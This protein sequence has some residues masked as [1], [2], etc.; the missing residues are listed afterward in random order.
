MNP[1]LTKY[2]ATGLI[3]FTTL[4]VFGYL[5]T[6]A[7]YSEHL[8]YNEQTIQMNN[9]LWQAFSVT[10]STQKAEQAY[11]LAVEHQD[12][13]Q[14]NEA[15]SYLQQSLEFS[16]L[17]AQTSPA[18][19]GNLVGQIADLQESLRRGGLDIEDPA[20]T[21]IAEDFSAAIQAA[22][23]SASLARTSFEESFRLSRTI[24]YQLQSTYELAVAVS[25]LLIVVIGWL[26]WRQRQ[27]NG[28]LSRNQNQLSASEQR[29]SLAMRGA[30]DGLWDWDLTTDNVYYSPRWCEMLGYRQDEL[31]TTLETWGNLV[32]PD[33][34]TR[35]LKMVD[36]YVQGT[37]DSFE[38]E[39]RMR[40]KDGHWVDL[41]SRAFLHRKDDT[42]VRLVG[43]HVDI[44]EHK[45]IQLELE[46]AR[47]KAEAASRSKSDFLATMS[48]EIRTPMNGVTGM[49][50]LLLDTRLNSEQREFAT[51]IQESAQALL[52]IINDVLD[53][54]RL[55]Q[56]HLNIE[57]IPFNLHHT[58]SSVIALLKSQALNKGIA[59]STDLSQLP[60][61]Q[62]TGDP[63]RV[64]Q[65]LMNL[66][67]NAVK[68]TDSGEVSV[69]VS[70]LQRNNQAWLRFEIQDSGIGIPEENIPQLFESFVQADSSITRN[71]GGSGLGLAISKGLVGAMGG[72]IGVQSQLNT[73]SL[74]WF[75][76]PTTFVATAV[77]E[78]AC[79]GNFTVPDFDAEQ[80]G[81]LEILI[82][83][84]NVTNQMV[85]SK[86]VQNLGHR[87]DIVSDGQEAVD[88]V[89]QKRY[90]L[91]Y[92]DVR[93]PRM[94][95]ITA[96]TLIRAHEG[97]HEHTP[98]IALTAN[99]TSD[100]VQACLAAGMDGFLSKPVNKDKVQGSLRHLT[101]SRSN[102]TA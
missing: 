39:F 79:E 3:L 83:E 2:F 11:L 4:L 93:M 26:F 55:E 64:R 15:L 1:S 20:A 62:I 49:I 32:H 54:S 73:G 85:I 57:S 69:T 98:I 82:V 76:V 65:I 10:L 52:L 70:T 28:E 80:P 58:V 51:V 16:D 12:Q 53:F 90:D 89:S 71:Y 21:R 5:R 44:S 6:D 31:G 97:E 56:G 40:H 66:I 35:A 33:D 75:E 61:Q 43:T 17:I 38:I 88:A 13:R 94:D 37:I 96:C 81:A 22:E 92:M 78:A 63:G 74:F 45:R 47:E 84:D 27:L 29:F 36:D 59:L 101:A 87:T 25:S 91:V 34:E 42:P 23:T 30:N 60:D 18:L 46:Q 102:P 86:L 7:H 68:F 24:E 50:S 67:G 19:A 14:L 9:A 95:G 72:E 100:D 41:L 77:S 8:T 48:H 99:A